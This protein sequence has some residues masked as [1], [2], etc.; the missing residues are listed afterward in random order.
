[1]ADF[2][3][4]RDDPRA[5]RTDDGEPAQTDVPDGAVQFEVERFGLTANNLTYAVFAD[6]WRYWDFFPAPPGWGRI[7]V[8]GFGRVSAS[9]VDGVAVGHR[10]YGYWP[11]SS[12]VTLPVVAGAAGLVASAP[13]RASLPAVYN[14][15]LSALPDT[16]FPPEHDD[17]AALV[18]PLFLTGWLIAHQLARAEWHGADAVVLT[19]ASS[20]TAWCT[21]SV[22]R[23]RDH[24][25]E[26][27]GLT[28]A[29]HVAATAGLGLYD[30]VL[31]YDE[32]DALPTDRGVV[33]VDVAGNVRTRSA[34]HSATRDVL[35]ASLM[36]GAT[37]WTQADFEGSGLPGPEPV[38]FFAPTVADETAA[39]LGP[40]AFAR[41]LGAAWS[42]F[43]A[44][45]LPEL[46]EIRHATGA[47]ALAEAY[48]SCLDGDVDP[49][50][51]WVFTV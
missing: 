51:G 35:R 12:R 19:S 37:H 30:Q 48:S 3:V 1:M 9:G 32:V 28:S 34:I 36:V 17:A 33:L 20:R 41:R 43:A 40:A 38:L 6:R 18:R 23:E 44:T 31:S 46:I 50:E 13:A 4:R 26:L 22:I 10:F 27:I 49:R 5:F 8:W 7:P 47:D 24:R 39:E 45:R 29:H 42:S 15:Y 14:R 2:L 21:A 16:G 25:P 11:M